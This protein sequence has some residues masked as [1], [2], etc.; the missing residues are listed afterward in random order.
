MHVFGF[1]VSDSQGMEA[2]LGF[3][4]ACLLIC[5]RKMIFESFAHSYLPIMYLYIQYS[6]GIT[7]KQN[8]MMLGI[9]QEEERTFADAENF[10]Q[11][12]LFVYIISHYIFNLSYKKRNHK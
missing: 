5:F 4:I 3:L 9:Q 11:T 12:S 6:I 8:D 1:K 2:A 10:C 7:A